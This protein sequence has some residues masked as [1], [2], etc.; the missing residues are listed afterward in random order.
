MRQSF[1]DEDLEPD[2]QD[3]QR[4]GCGDEQ[5]DEEMEPSPSESSI[6]QRLLRMLSIHDGPGDCDGGS[7]I[8]WR[9]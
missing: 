2:Q 8:S 6:P 3:Q 5:G 9:S 7:C 1:E 4:S